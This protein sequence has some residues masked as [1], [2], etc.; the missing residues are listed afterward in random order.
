[1]MR[2]MRNNGKG[3]T[4]I[5]LML[6]MGIVVLL[7]GFAVLSLGNYQKYQELDSVG[8]K[9][10][11]NLRDAQQKSIT[12][13]EGKYWGLKFYDVADPGNDYF[14]VIKENSSDVITNYF[15]SHIV[16]GTFSID[17][18]P[19]NCSNTP[20]QI[21]FEKLS[22]AITVPNNG[23]LITV[24]VKIKDAACSDPS[25]CRTITIKKN[26]TVEY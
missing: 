16:F 19:A 7:P 23:T 5:E 24:T 17:G 10:V 20:C 21:S 6:V 15:G 2:I 3:F 25:R 14:E 18:T 9:I 26:G 4:L 13:E 11:L 8:R 22:G 1:M 12:Q